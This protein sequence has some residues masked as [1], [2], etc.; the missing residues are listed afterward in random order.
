MVLVVEVVAAVLAVGDL[1]FDGIVAGNVEDGVAVFV[2]QLAS[3]FDLNMGMEV[4]AGNIVVDMA[5]AHN[6]Y[7]AFVDTAASSYFCGKDKF[8]DVRNDTKVKEFKRQ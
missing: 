5:A 8:E 2:D 4:V 3:H 7:T 6:H 1:D